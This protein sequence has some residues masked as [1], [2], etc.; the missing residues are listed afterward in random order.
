MRKRPVAVTEKKLQHLQLLLCLGVGIICSLLGSVGTHVELSLNPLNTALEA[1]GQLGKH[2]TGRSGGA[3][4]EVHPLLA[5]PSA[6]LLSL[7]ALGD[8]LLFEW[9]RIMTEYKVSIYGSR[10]LL[11][12]P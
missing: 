5:S 8:R 11:T 12:T 9:V 2:G 3:V 1:L 7:G 10:L 6:E 4:L